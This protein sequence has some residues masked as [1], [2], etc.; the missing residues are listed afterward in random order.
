M[1]RQGKGRLGVDGKATQAGNDNAERITGHSSTVPTVFH[2]GIPADVYHAKTLG[3][4][5]KGALGYVARSP[6]HYLSWIKGA[7]RDEES[8]AF[9]IG[10]TLHCA[11]WSRTR[12]PAIGVVAPNFGDQRF[13]QNKQAKADWIAANEGRRSPATTSRRSAGWSRA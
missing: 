13:K 7:T 10:T 2:P 11:L 6:A 5:S 4:V 3:L 1:A 9:E 8:P 12:S